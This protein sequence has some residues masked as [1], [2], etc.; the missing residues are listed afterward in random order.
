MPF[1]TQQVTCPDPASCPVIS[2]SDLLSPMPITTLRAGTQ[3]FR[4]YDGTWGY[5]EPNPGYGDARFSPF[6]ALWDGHRV[7]ALY[8]AE[9]EVGALLETVFHDVHHAS[10]RRIYEQD[11]RVRLLAHLEVPVDLELVDL[12]DDVL[13]A[14]TVS[15]EEIVSSPSEHYPCTRLIAQY[16]YD[17]Y[18]ETGAA[19]G[20]MWHS[21]QAELTGNPPTM[22]IVVYTDSYGAG[23]GG[24]MRIG[25]GSQ[26]LLEGPGRLRVDAIAND[27]G[28]TIVIS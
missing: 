10:V 7:P 24:W 28:A 19:H 23:R 2:P 11:L 27:L 17:T 12:R 1:P 9:T 21:R 13:E 15:R 4:V 25:P 18:I 6:D 20:L 16:L 14:A 26:N 22:A 8:A 5:D 3:L